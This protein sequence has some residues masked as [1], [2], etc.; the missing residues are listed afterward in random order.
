MILVTGASGF[1]G[2]ALVKALVASGAPVR[3]ALRKPPAKSQLASFDTVIVGELGPDTIWARALEGVIAVVHLAGPAHAKTADA[4]LRRAIVDG[5][6]A[7]AEQAFRAGIERFVLVSSIKAA[8]ARTCGA[9]LSER[10]MPAPEDGY[11]RAKLEAEQA[12]L[13]HA[14]LSPVVVR[15]PLVFAPHAKG[16]F[17]HLLRLADTILPLP[18]GRIENRRSLISLA[19]LVEAIR[20]AIPNGPTGTYHV[21]D[22][23]ALSTSEILTALRVGMG[24]RARLFYFPGLSSLAPR[25]LTESFEIDASAFRHAFGWRGQDSRAALIACGGAWKQSR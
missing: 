20:V 23:P 18:L 6:A 7:L 19:S 4:V 12:V 16:N 3:A 2:A 21:A 25:A 10:A 8:A 17:T 24:R 22:T 1:V 9:A 5:T 15:A 14:A 13:A 11:G